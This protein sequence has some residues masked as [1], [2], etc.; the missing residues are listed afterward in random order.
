MNDKF[1]DL[2]REPDTRLYYR[3]A[4]SLGGFDALFEWWSWEGHIEADSLIFCS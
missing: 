1:S 3:K 4:F 2:Q